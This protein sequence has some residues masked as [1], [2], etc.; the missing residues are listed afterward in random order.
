MEH[1]DEAKD[2]L[3]GCLFIPKDK[4]SDDA[5]IHSIKGLDS[6]SFETIVVEIEQRTGKD[7]DPMQLLEMVTV[8]DLANLLKLARQ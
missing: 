1:L 8:R 2:I 5:S 4:I 3:S 7:V 6:L